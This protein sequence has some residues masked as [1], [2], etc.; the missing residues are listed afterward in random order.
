MALLD[1]AYRGVLTLAAPL[2]R[3]AAP[4]NDKLARGVAER[5]AAVDRCE[6]WAARGRNGRPLIWLH[7]PSV[8]EG[9]MAQAIARALREQADVQIALTIFSPSAERLLHDPAFDFA[10]YLPWDTRS[11]M[12]RAVSALRPAAVGFVR[13]EI[14]PELMREA[15]AAGARCAL[16]NGVLAEDSSRLRWPA[17]ALLAPSYQTLDAV[18]AVTADHA[19]R[20]AGLGVSAARTHV[21]GDAR[22]DQVA[23]R[24]AALD[25][26]QPLLRALA[27]GRPTIVAGSTWP[28]DEELLATA[29]QQLSTPRPRLILAPHEPSDAHVH[30]CIARFRATGTSVEPLQAI[31][32]ATLPDVIVIDR[33]GI[34]ADI[35]AAAQIAYVGGGFGTAGLHSVVEPA[36]L[37]VPVLFGPRHGNALEAGELAAAGGGRVVHDAAELTTALQRWLTND[38]DRAAAARSAQAFFDGR[39]GGAARNAELLS[40]FL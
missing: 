12:R 21:T 19:A 18:G 24:L 8:G 1:R 14:W 31:Q 38:A 16:V 22:F 32:G 5:A 37:G 25:R 11:N 9:L 3:L 30:G 27:D 7:A 23:A 20:F 28:R 40:G 35:Y 6:Q 34:L 29:F 15:R 2:T 17:R 4:F 13:T 10:G 26:S 33:V 36:G 39:L